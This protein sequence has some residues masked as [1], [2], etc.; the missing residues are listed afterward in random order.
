LFPIVLTVI[1]ILIIY[2]GIQYQRYS[3]KIEQW[4]AQHLPD[5]IK[6]LLP[7]YRDKF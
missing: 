4:M 2:L 5:E 7:Q 6:R 3:P 1:G